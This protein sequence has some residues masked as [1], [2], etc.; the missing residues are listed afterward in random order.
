MPC[1]ASQ[2]PGVSSTYRN[3]RGETYDA[4]LRGIAR[5]TMP[6]ILPFASRKTMSSGTNVFA[7]VNGVVVSDGK[8]KNIDSSG[9]ILR[10]NE[11]PR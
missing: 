4:E 1:A 11:N 10:R 6:T 3:G 8:T 7:I 2:P 5:F 9:N